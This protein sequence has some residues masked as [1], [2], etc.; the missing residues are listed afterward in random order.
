ME[1]PEDGSLIG[2]PVGKAACISRVNSKERL[3]HSGRQSW[4]DEA[5]QVLW[6][7]DDPIMSSRYRK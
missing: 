1:V 5:K 7:P 3:V 6:S 4:R 2:C